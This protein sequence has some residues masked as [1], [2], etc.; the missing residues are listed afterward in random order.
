[1]TLLIGMPV[2]FGWIMVG[3]VVLLIGSYGWKRWKGR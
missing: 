1:M 2:E 3:Y